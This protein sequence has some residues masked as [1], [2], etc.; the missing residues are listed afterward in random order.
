MKHG[1]LFFLFIFGLT[2]ARAQHS[3]R[4]WQVDPLE[5]VLRESRAF[6]ESTG[7]A[8]VARGETASFQL[9]WLNPA[10]T[11]DL[12][13]EALPLRNGAARLPVTRIGYAGY[14]HVGR[15][16]PTP[17]K[18]KIASPSG[19]YPD[20]L[21]GVQAGMQLPA[22]E[23]QPF[24]LS[25]AVPAGA[26]P[27]L[28]SGEVVFRGRSN[29]RPFRIARPLQLQVYP[30]TIGQT[31]LWV[32]NWMN[33][34]AHNLRHLNGGQAVEPWSERYWTLVGVLAGSAARHGQNMALISPLAL[35]Q[36]SLDGDRYTFD[37]SRFDRMTGLFLQ[38]GMR[39]IEGGHLGGR[40]G[41]WT[42]PFGVSVPSAA[43]ASGSASGM[44][45]LPLDDERTRR[46]LDQFL[47]AFLA[48]LKEKNWESIYL[49][50][51]ADEPIAEN[52]DS[53]RAF[54]AYVRERLPGIPIVEANHA[55]SLAGSI[56]VW[57]PQL[58]FL[59]TDFAFYL[60]RQRLGEEIWFYTCLAP[61]G[62]YANRFLELPLIQTRLLHW[63]NYRYGIPGYLHW[64]Y[65]FWN[66]DP[67]R[68]A[69]GIITESGN[70]LPG[71]DAWVAYPG[72]GEVIP[73]LRLEAMRDGIYDYELLKMYEVK[74]PE[75]ARELARQVV[76]QFDLYD[77]G[78]EAFR[79]KR[80]EI[81]EALSQ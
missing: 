16:T 76:Y 63:L 52:I 3:I 21:P 46:F 26:A 79:A 49:Q 74:F 73:S 13:V 53:Y 44:E 68:E 43:P 5:K 72:N 14:V 57:V 24:W 15:Q 6:L 29:G 36:F 17:S 45:M 58:N 38:A 41:N 59:H 35:T 7:P 34:S 20:P 78:I 12:T 48:H 62:N 77:S 40:I 71:G 2:S 51:I 31:S 67:F 75:R 65:N 10:A 42:S 30:V 37:F 8:E 4:I 33:L 22:G 25:V 28:Y 55:S 81:L 9:V 54:S 80:R 66:D 56:D 47:P 27:G 11:D 69:T 1:L 32:T 19:F 50:H 61:Q 60:E 23:L 70:T 39:R 64:G 18:D